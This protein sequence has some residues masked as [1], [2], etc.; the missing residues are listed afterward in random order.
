MR[1]NHREVSPIVIRM[2]SCAYSFVDRERAPQLGPQVGLARV[3]AS[4]PA[5][6]ADASLRRRLAGGLAVA[7]VLLAVGPL[8]GVAS[9]QSRAPRAPAR[10]TSK[11]P[12]RAIFYS[13]AP[14]RS[15]AATKRLRRTAVTR[16][17]VARQLAA[18]RWA[19]ADVAIMPWSRPGFADDRAL[20]A[21]LAAGAK[22][23][24]RV[25][26]A[27]LIDR[28]RGTE[29]SQI[30]ALAS[31][32]VSARGYLHIG[33]R[34]AVFVALANRARRNCM[35]A[36]RWRVAAAGFWLAQGTF[37]GYERCSTAANAWFSDH[38]RARSA[39]APGTFVI[40]PWLPAQASEGIAIAA[41]CRCLA[42][43]GRAHERLRSA[44]P[45]DRVAERLG[46]RDCDRTEFCLAFAQPLRTLPRRTARTL[47]ETCPPRGS[48]RGR[49]AGAHLA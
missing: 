7:L 8:G 25:R 28:R 31:R 13:A 38:G 14:A 24:R 33:S 17:A 10:A 27:V 35:A 36:R 47:T 6:A 21:V 49:G 37:A 44:P 23:H 45:A 18:L 16:R 1:L 40:R 22:H 39:R 43:C 29:V 15:R 30:K 48:S 34:P 5:R 41:L 12:L 3:A 11:A 19:R 4:S 32:R 46:Q 20:R 9:A 26:V 2:T 42:A